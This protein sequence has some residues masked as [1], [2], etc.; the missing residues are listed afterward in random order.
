M[1]SI[2]AQT[3]DPPLGWLTPV[4]ISLKCLMQNFWIGIKTCLV[5]YHRSLWIGA[6]MLIVFK[7][8]IWIDSF[9]ERINWISLTYG[10][11][12]TLGYAACVFLVWQNNDERRSTLLVAKTKVAPIKSKSF[13]VWNVVLLYLDVDYYHQLNRYKE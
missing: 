6:K 11:V 3:F 10:S 8:P 12:V 13:F 2:F 1:L 4:I 9:C 7:R 5:T